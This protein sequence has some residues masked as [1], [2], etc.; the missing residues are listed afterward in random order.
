MKKRKLNPWFSPATFDHLRNDRETPAVDERI[1]WCNI[2]I[3]PACVLKI[4]ERLMVVVNQPI[5]CANQAEPSELTL[6]TARIHSAIA[7]EHFNRCVPAKNLRLY[8]S[9][10][11]AQLET[12]PK[13]RSTLRLIKSFLR[14]S[15]L[16]EPITAQALASAVLEGPRLRQPLKLPFSSSKTENPNAI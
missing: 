3:Q 12:D 8:N 2:A 1:V 6:L 16:A 13:L 10:N 5:H 11:G 15:S 14:R 7:Y 9:L 4:G